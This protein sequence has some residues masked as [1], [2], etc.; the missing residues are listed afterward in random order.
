[1]A[2]DAFH[3]R[4]SLKQQNKPFKS[5]H[6]TKGQLKAK[7]KGKVDDTT[8]RTNAANA[9][10][11]KVNSSKADRR[12]AAKLVQQRKKEDIVAANRLF[13][14]AEGAPKIVAVVPLCPDVD[15]RTV[16]KHIFESV[17]EP[18]YERPGPITLDV[19]RFRQ[20]LQLI[21][22]NSEKRNLLH[23]LDAVKVAD[24]VLFVV[25]AEV[26][27][28]SFGE[29]VLSTIKAQGVPTVLSV[30]Q[31]LEKTPA[32]TH[33]DIRKSLTSYME[34]H[35]PGD[36]KLFHAAARQ[37]SLNMLR[38][39]TSVRP[40]G[41]AWRE[42]HPYMLGEELAFQPNEDDESRG[43]LQ[44]SGVLRGSPLTAN[45]LVH[46]Q[47]HGDFQI[48]MITSWPRPTE[49]KRHAPSK[50][51]LRNDSMDMD[52]TAPTTMTENTHMQTTAT[53]I[54][55]A[56]PDPEL[57]ES[58]VT[59]NEPDPM[60]GEQTWPTEEELAEAE[61][62]VRKMQE[63]EG[64]SEAGGDH[65]A[66]FGAGRR[67]SVGAASVG[68]T[69][70]KGTAGRKVRVPKGTSSYQAAWIID[71]VGS[72]EEDD[73]EEEEAA[74][75]MGGMDFDMR[76]GSV[77]GSSSS[78]LDKDYVDEDGEEYEE[79]DAD[80]RADKFDDDYDEEA[81]RE[82][83]ASF[84]A[85]KRLNESQT[86][87]AFPDELDTPIDVP[88]RIRFQ[89]YRGLKS[90]RTSP[91]DANENLPVDYARIFAFQKWGKAQARVM[92]WLEKERSGAYEDEE[93][94]MEEEEA[95]MD[96]E[97]SEASKKG[98][99]KGKAAKTESPKRKSLLDAGTRVTLH[100]ENVPRA[101][102]DTHNP[103]KPFVVF[104]LLPHEQRMSVLN[105]VVQPTFGPN[106]TAPST[107]PT[108]TTDDAASTTS[109]SS[110]P[111]VIKSKDPLL[112]HCGFRRY[113]VRPLYST[114]TRGGTN[115]VHKFERF[116][117]PGRV[118]VGTCYA[119]IQFGPAPVMLF[120]VDGL[121][122][123]AE[124]AEGEGMVTEQTHATSLT[125]VGNGSII[126]CDP[127]RILAKRLILTG[128]PFKIHKRS[129]VIRFM[130][131]NPQD[132]MWFKPVQLS[133]KYGRTGHIK[134]SLGTHGY[135]KC[136][137]DGP[138]K[139]HDTVCMYLYKRVFPKWDTK[140]FVE[141]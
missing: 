23:I 38:Y 98:K 43:T 32:K 44:V 103:D 65:A 75:H 2:Q 108:T 74:P 118:S 66:R 129:A 20:R 3:H 80:E 111:L 57:Q 19:P 107:Q 89:K 81:E 136:I 34:H 102:Y 4:S 67:G 11:K 100:L 86:D 132:V 21:P 97:E 125:F 55:L 8:A 48:K 91:W 110:T 113:I 73:E 46:L 133:T 115:N 123:D 9:A 62:R 137:F 1:M 109:T 13:Q 27:V 90:F 95:G 139:A 42:R 140:L 87:L 68:A 130:F 71:E 124:G 88:A 33:A 120:K 79:I 14:G 50:A 39:I 7:T 18:Y 84:L 5:K 96:V 94:D 53:S 92:K 12:N 63:M 141:G 37:E 54:V 106:T 49:P 128:H 6:S 69:S 45:K 82:Q 72:D 28:D 117:Q 30:V 131:H 112:L 127:T 85:Q 114:N 60:D 135:M 93:E 99:G 16:V 17:D 134:E 31:H 24:Y 22:L 15:S 61:E 101:A 40:K 77:A 76:D 78:M 29:L 35:F 41:V 116:L 52:D 25:S 64:A 47:N 10:R 104:A 138:I 126:S 119:P 105:F 26:E 59:E 58:L 56:V 83:Y 70:S 122:R 121:E 51:A 36:Q